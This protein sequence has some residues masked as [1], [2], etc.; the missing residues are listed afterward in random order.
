MAEV[1]GQS[2]DSM[3]PRRVF[4]AWD[5]AG[6]LE[7]VG[8]FVNIVHWFCYETEGV[9]AAPLF[10]FLFK[11]VDY[12]LTDFFLGFHNYRAIVYNQFLT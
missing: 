4:G 2:V 10:S 11:A 1:H 9:I 8:G 3:F 7:H 5:L 12:K 6:P